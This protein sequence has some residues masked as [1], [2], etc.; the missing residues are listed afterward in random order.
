MKLLSKARGKA[1]FV[2]TSAQKVKTVAPTELW[3]TKLELKKLTET[4]GQINKKFGEGS[5]LRASDAIALCV[6]RIPFGITP[7]D[8]SVGGGLPLGRISMFSGMRSSGKTA[9]ALRSVARA[10]RTCAV[11]YQSLYSICTCKKPRPFI[12]CWLDAEGVWDNAWSAKF[13]IN[14]ELVFVIRTDYAEQAVDV[15]DSMLRTGECDLLIVDSVAALTPRVEVEESMDKQ[16]MGVAA[17][18]INKAVRKWQSSLNRSGVG[19]DRRPTVLLINQI[20]MKVG[21]VWGNPETHPGGLGQEFASSLILKMTAVGYEG[22]SSDAD[23]GTK[24]HPSML[25]IKAKVEKSKVSPPKG[26]VQY[27]L[28][29]RNVA[30]HKVG[31]VE[32]ERTL[33]DGALEAKLLDKSFRLNGRAL[34]SAKAA[35]QYLFE[36]P[37]QRERLRLDV[38]KALIQ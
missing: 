29:L 32:D 37:E 1:A 17:R 30:G 25:T 2:Q 38:L 36:H 26:E 5:I 13:G 23:A 7:L 14:N 28:W 15:A 12:C 21:M 8:V 19:S 31:D 24:S 10:Q 20:R 11:C 9:L 35:T 33:L 34:G 16:Q 4:V 3:S 18:I 27:T 6:P 22:A